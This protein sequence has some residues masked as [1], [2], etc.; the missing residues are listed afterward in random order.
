MHHIAPPGLARITARSQSPPP[1]GRKQRLPCSAC[2]A[3]PRPGGEL[4]RPPADGWQVHGAAPST[5]R[6]CVCNG[7][8]RAAGNGA[9]SQGAGSGRAFCT[10]MC[11]S[12]GR[13]HFA[14]TAGKGRRVRQER[15]RQAGGRRAGGRGIGRHETDVQA[16]EGREK[17]S[18]KARRPVTSQPDPQ[19]L[20]RPQHAP[21]GERH[22]LAASQQALP[23]RHAC[24]L[25]IHHCTRKGGE[26]RGGEGVSLRE[27]V[28]CY[29][30]RRMKGCQPPATKKRRA[31]GGPA[32]RSAGRG[33]TSC[34]GQGS[35]LDGRRASPHSPLLSMSST[36]ASS[37]PCR[38]SVYASS[39]QQSNETGTRVQSGRCLS[40]TSQS[41]AGPLCRNTPQDPQA[42]LTTGTHHWRTTGAASPLLPSCAQ[43]AHL[44]TS[45]LRGWHT[46]EA[47]SCPATLWRGASAPSAAGAASAGGVEMRRRVG[48]G[49]SE[50]DG[51]GAAQRAQEPLRHCCGPHHSLS[52]AQ[53]HLAAATAAL[54]LLPRLPP[55]PRRRRRRVCEQS[56]RRQGGPGRGWPPLDGR[57]GRL[58]E[59]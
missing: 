3:L 25:C 24:R 4:Q 41:Q 20:V 6:S 47:A 32:G 56:A 22:A 48:L 1:A 11:T 18:C 7:C 29:S 52:T 33:L 28:G 17:M 36:S 58:R 27:T 5:P 51:S 44:N 23:R 59:A 37:I 26:G 54:P 46:T 35:T 8:C 9:C 49:R 31:A 53:A 34:C 39:L 57:G 16:G 15:D 55:P 38:Q 13:C 43:P 14:E 12:L 10:W 21:H 40:A 42:A 2:P 50:G 45:R 19:P 30:S